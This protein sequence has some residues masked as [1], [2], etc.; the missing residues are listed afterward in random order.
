LGA[1]SIRADGPWSKVSKT[2]KQKKRSFVFAATLRPLYKWNF[3]GMTRN[4]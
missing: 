2:D 3:F 4:N 1:S